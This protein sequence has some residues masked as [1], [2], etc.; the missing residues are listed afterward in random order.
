[1]KKL[2]VVS[3]MVMV[4][5]FGATLASA[6]Q[7]NTGCGLGTLLFPQ[8]DSVLME[9]L[10]TCTNGT[11]GNQTFGITTGTLNCK[12]PA[13]IV[14]NE[15]LDEFVAYNLDTLAQEI[16]AGEGESLA[17]LAELMEVPTAKRAEFY[18]TLQGNFTS[19]F[20]SGDVQSAD[21]IDNIVKVTQES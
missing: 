17:T 12:K 7:N 10:V 9:V 8:A 3:I 2:L 4:L 20:T 18:A 14:L 21:V 6:N 13:S 11:S 5:M 16:A 1:M 19:I 15:K